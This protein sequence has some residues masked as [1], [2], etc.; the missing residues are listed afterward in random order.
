MP[1]STNGQ[2]L[3]LQLGAATEVMPEGTAEWWDK[4][5]RTGFYKQ[6]RTDPQWLGYEGLRG[7]EQAD[8][9]FHGGVD[10][11]VCV[12]A[13]EHY[14]HWLSMLPLEALPHGAFGENFTTTGLLEQ[15]VCVGD[16]YTVGGAR[17]QISQP[18]QP[19]WILARRWHI[20]DL[21]AQVERTGFTGFY[22]RVLHH[23]AVAAGAAFELQERPFPRW[24]VGLCNAVM[25]HGEGGD[26]AAREL[27]QCAALSGSWKDELWGR[28]GSSRP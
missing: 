8:R 22:F 9:R 17:V 28:S 18:R 7:D 4:P 27:S 23:G 6:P 15:E 12:Y 20:K 16:V 13:S 19:C 11:A 14:V 25:N 24:T 2:L 5:W 21:A 26:E 1:M 10:K 3:S